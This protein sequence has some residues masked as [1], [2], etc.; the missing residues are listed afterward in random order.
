MEYIVE[1]KGSTLFVRLS[2]GDELFSGIK[3]A[4]KEAGVTQG[5]ITSCIGS[6]SETHYTYVK[7]ADT[8]TKM[9]YRDTIVTDKANE[10]ICGQGTIGMSGSELDI[11]MHALMCDIEGTLFA[12]HMMPGSIIAATMEI[13]IAVSNSGRIAREFDQKLQFPL[14][15]FL[16]K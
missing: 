10:L 7:S 5:T 14:F 12:G 16:P 6:L 13:S 1:P 2:M 8:V 9:A 15:Q 3:Q 11:H 4:C